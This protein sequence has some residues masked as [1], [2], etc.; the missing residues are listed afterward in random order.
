MYPKVSSDGS[1]LSEGKKPLFAKAIHHLFN[2]GFEPAGQI[3][4][5]R[6]SPRAPC[7]DE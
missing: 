3:A 4:V 7:D 5:S 6:L 2:D 1:N